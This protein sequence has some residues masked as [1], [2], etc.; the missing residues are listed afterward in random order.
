VKTISAGVNP[1]RSATST[2][3]IELASAALPSE[4]TSRTMASDEF[5]FI[6]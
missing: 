5:A 2:S 3:P 6:A 1:Q 4:R